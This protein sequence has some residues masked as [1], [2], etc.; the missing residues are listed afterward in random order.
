MNRMIL[1]IVSATPLLLLVS[2][3]RADRQVRISTT[4]PAAAFPKLRALDTLFEVAASIRSADAEPLRALHVS[5]NWFQVA[6]NPPLL[7]RAFL[8]DEGLVP[9]VA[10][11]SSDAWQ[12]LFGKDPTI[13]GHIIDVGTSKCTVVGIVPERSGYDIDVYLPWS[14][15][16]DGYSLI[17]LLRPGVS[18]KQAQAAMDASGVKAKL[19]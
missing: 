19:E 6:Q 3:G 9:T 13:I 12:R 10:I 17:A 15:T 18:L 7:G 4:S 8:A 1:S 5:T 2:C 14:P 16:G 11:L